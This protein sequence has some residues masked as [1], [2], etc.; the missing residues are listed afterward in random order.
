M[1]TWQTGRPAGAWTELGGMFP[2][3]ELPPCPHCGTAAGTHCYVI[4]ET[5]PESGPAN[6]WSDDL[7]M[8]F[9]SIHTVRWELYRAHD[10]PV[11]VSLF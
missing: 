6:G 4:T 11:Q 10:E 5:L 8:R 3:R 2:A 9:P 1:T 7:I